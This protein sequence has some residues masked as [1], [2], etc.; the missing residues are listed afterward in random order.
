M[1][2][3]ESTAQT[4]EQRSAERR[5]VE[6]PVRVRLKTDSFEGV[7]DNVSQA[8]IMLFTDQPLEVEVDVTENGEV[9]SY[10]GRIV[11]AQRMNDSNTGFAIE[12]D[13]A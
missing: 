6:A 7:S 13:D 12:F 9:T 3:D 8:G 1:S 10:T 2:I 11:R 4:A 5:V